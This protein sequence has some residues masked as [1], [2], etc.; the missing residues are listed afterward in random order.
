MDEF[1]E[2]AINLILTAMTMV[3]AL[4][5]WREDLGHAVMYASSIVFLASVGALLLHFTTKADKALRK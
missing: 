4:L 3:S 5:M 1:T 2:N